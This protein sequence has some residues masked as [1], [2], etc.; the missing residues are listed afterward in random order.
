MP[1][2]MVV[3]A[4]TV[5]VSAVARLPFVVLLIDTASAFHSLIHR[6]D[7]DKPSTAE[8]DAFS[9]LEKTTEQKAVAKTAEQRLI[10][11]Y[12]YSA[13]TTEDPDRLNRRLRDGF[14]S[15]K[16][17]RIGQEEADEAVRARYGLAERIALGPPET[18]EGEGPSSSSATSSS[19]GAAIWRAE[20]A[21]RDRRLLLAGRSLAD[22]ASNDSSGRKGKGRESQ[23]GSVDRLRRSVLANTARRFHPFA[24][25]TTA[26]T[27]KGSSTT[28]SD[29]SS[30]LS[31][32]R[33]TASPRPPPSRGRT[34]LPPP[35]NRVSKAPAPKAAFLTGLPSAA[36]AP[37]GLVDYESD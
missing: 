15:E 29:I 36:V 8:A 6:V 25:P 3:T 32:A 24:T 27:A 22:G 37:P 35:K 7:P 11:L 16:K 18:D 4:R 28:G 34:P 13:R 33:S 21:E 10:D 19:S 12:A 9:Q 30:V 1:R 23:A 2:I 14:R 20:Q 31:S 17:A 5:R 26:T